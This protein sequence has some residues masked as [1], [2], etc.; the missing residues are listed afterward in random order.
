[1]SLPTYPW[2]D[3]VPDHLKTRN[4]LAEQGLRPGGPVV[5]QV[6]WK[7]GKRWADLYDVNAAQPK[8]E[9][10]PAQLAALEK[11]RAA[12]RLCYVCGT[13]IG[14]A[15]WA[16]FRPERDC[17]KCSEEHMQSIRKRRQADAR[18][19]A[20]HARSWLGSKRTVI[21][22][23]ETTDLSGYLMQIAVI[24]T[25]GAVLLDT[26]VNPQAP[27]EPGAY[28]VHR[29]SAEM[30]ADA[31][32]FA[33]IE[34]ELRSVLG[35]RRIV[36]YNASFDREILRNELMRLYGPPRESYSTS[37]EERVAWSD[38]YKA[39]SAH[40]DTWL[41]RRRWRCAMHAYAAWVGDWSSYHGSYRWHPLIGGDHSALGDCRAC[42]A[43]LW[44]M[45]AEDEKLSR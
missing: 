23:T 22:D 34:P 29:I 15:L 6:V 21:L 20:R 16:R 26:F 37:Y 12:Q 10:T 3:Q 17:P 7:R 42:L 25:S 9:A 36:T 41:R 35:G 43:V 18:E 38:A 4:Q 33:Q 13:D 24:D 45:A 2:F 39:A 28:A 40:A 27:I 11:A 19:A 32:T 30:V 14:Q 5:A 1:M 44:R 8:Q 31:P